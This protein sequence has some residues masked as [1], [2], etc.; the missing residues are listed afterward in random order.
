MIDINIVEKGACLR[1]IYIKDFALKQVSKSIA[2]R[3]RQAAGRRATCEDWQGRLKPSLQAWLALCSFDH[4]IFFS[5]EMLLFGFAALP[6]NQ[7]CVATLASVLRRSFLESHTWLSMQF[8]VEKHS[9]VEKEVNEHVGQSFCVV[10][11]CR[12]KGKFL[13]P[14]FHYLRNVSLAEGRV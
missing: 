8:A 1:L 3:A 6:P 9:H 7:K 14:I 5:L 2:H 10:T 11:L 4:N 12:L 13:P